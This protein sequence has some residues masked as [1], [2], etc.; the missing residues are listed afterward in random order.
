MP[1]ERMV[2]VP[3]R[4]LIAMERCANAMAR[5]AN[6]SLDADA[7]RELAREFSGPALHLYLV[8]IVGHCVKVGI[9]TDPKRR[10]ADHEANARKLGRVVG[11]TW[12]TQP[13]VEARANERL[14]KGD[15]DTEYLPRSFEDVLAQAESLPMTC[16]EVSH[17]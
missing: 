15:H 2:L 6:S 14:I 5:F 9:T 3:E 7:L 1:T 12:V 4:V 16:V 13:H 8:E 10:I 11:R 17:G